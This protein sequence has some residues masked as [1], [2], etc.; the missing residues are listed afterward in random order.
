MKWLT[1]LVVTSLSASAQQVITGNPVTIQ[2]KLNVVEGLAYLKT[3]ASPNLPD[4]VMLWGPLPGAD[5]R[6]F[7]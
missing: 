6:A 3:E 1:G 5:Y 7:R 2:G 4:C